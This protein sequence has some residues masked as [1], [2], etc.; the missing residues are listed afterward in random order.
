MHT[1]K[2]TSLYEMELNDH[3]GPD[4]LDAIATRVYGRKYVGQQTGDMLPNDS[5]HVYDI[6]EE[7]VAE[8]LANLSEKRTYLGIRRVAA[9]T[10]DFG[11]SVVTCYAEGVDEFEYW[12][13]LKW[14]PNV[15]TVYLKPDHSNLNEAIASQQGPREWEDA[16]DFTLKFESEVYRRAP[17][18][19]SVLADLVHRG[20]L[21]YGRYLIHCWW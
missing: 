7:A 5:W 15:E 2:T 9:G 11:T 21:P 4:S 1:P 14:D 20:E 3:A 6:D 19:H 8:H 16:R 17:E 10:G 18:V 13:S 12:L